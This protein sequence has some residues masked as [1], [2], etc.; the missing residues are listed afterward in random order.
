MK[1]IIS[2]TTRGAFEGVLSDIKA[3]LCDGGEC[4]VLTTDRMTATVERA[5]LDSMKVDGRAC[6]FNLDVTTF[7][8]LGTK[9][10]KCLPSKCLTPEGSV[11]LLADV[12]AKRKDDLDY[13][14]NA[15]HINGFASELYA[16]FTS[17]RNSGISSLEL[18]E[19]SESF[20]SSLKRKMSDL[21]S[22]YEGYLEAL[23][24]RYIDSTTRLEAFTK[25]LKDISYKGENVPKHFYVID[26][27]DFS[28]PQLDVLDALNSCA[29]SLTVGAVSG[30]KNPN[31]RIYPDYAIEK[32]KA[33]VDN[34]PKINYLFEDLDA[35][36]DAASKNLFGYENVAPVE[37]PILIGKEGEG[38]KRRK[39]KLISTL[40]RRDEVLNLVL[41]IVQKV[42]KGARY[43]DIEVL[44]SDLKGYE[45]LLKSTLT[46][47]GV[48][49][50]TDT[51]QL[52]SQQ[53]KV[54]FLLSAI[55]AVRSSLR[56]EEVLDFV[57][58]PLFYNGLD[59]DEIYKEA[60]NGQNTDNQNKAQNNENQNSAKSENKA[61]GEDAV[62]KF[63]NYVL[64][65]G[66]NFG[67]FNS[68]FS[69]GSGELL[70]AA[71]SVRKQLIYALS[72]FLSSKNGADIG[73]FIEASR[74]FLD[75][76][77]GV[78]AH[79][80]G[81]L[82]SLSAY[83]L[84]CAEQVDSKIK[85]VLDEIEDVLDG[86]YDIDGFELILKSM[87]QKLTISLVPTY[88]D[89]VFV[90]DLESRFIGGRD[91]YILGANAGLFPTEKSGG[92][93]LT[94]HD[95]EL[96]E[97]VGLTLSPNAKRKVL[98][99]LFSVT[100]AIK[101]VRGEL[102]V[103]YA[104]SCPSGPLKPSTVVAQ[105]QS[106]ICQDKKPLP[107]ERVVFDDYGAERMRGT[108]PKVKQAFYDKISALFSSDTACRY[109]VLNNAISA[110]A[111]YGDIEYYRAAYS[112]LSEEEKRPIERLY[113]L[114]E[115]LELTP[116]N[117]GVTTM[118][119]S[120]SRLECY[121][122]C[123][124]MYFL[125]YT[126][127]LKER[128]EGQIKTLEHGT[129]LHYILECFY[130]ALK[131]GKATEKNATAIASSAFYDFVNN[132]EK[133]S[134]ILSG[135]GADSRQLLRVKEEGEK[136][137]NDLYALSLRSEFKPA[138]LEAYFGQGGE[139]KPI[140]VTVDGVKVELEGK[141]DRVDRCG[142]YFAVIDYKTYKGAALPLNEVYYG[143]KLQLYVYVEALYENL[144]LKPAG[145][146]Y[147]PI[148]QAFDAENAR[149][150]LRGQ[151]SDD[152]DIRRLLD[153]NSTD[154]N[155][156]TYLPVAQKG[157]K[158]LNTYLSEE[159]F[160]QLAEYAKALSA[161]GARGIL[162]GYVKP[163]PA[164]GACAYCSY[165]T[166]CPYKE[167][168]VRAKRNQNENAFEI[169]EESESYEVNIGETGLDEKINMQCF[170]DGQKTSER[171]KNKGGNN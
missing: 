25:Y 168:N 143:Q 50:F 39:I 46:R 3:V 44:V 135:G 67:V 52:L 79:H 37:N 136:A 51:K 86:K 102:V 59:L 107:V 161:E 142:N 95:E 60:N 127:R 8:R 9:M 123:P 146:F 121:Y 68:P 114:P 147:L 105:L 82:T 71:E 150:K 138:Y 29:L 12:L 47:Y 88:L 74:L 49:Y 115:K 125:N 131:N 63:E 75:E 21:A 66:A 163:V 151:V 42:R 80:T 122:K 70:L 113:N 55:A 5:L 166:I 56:R 53:T 120:V 112:F 14:R 27:T 61:S 24:G 72:P 58:N 30:M 139:L 65:Y 16:A 57:K 153:C 148:F 103:S 33:R 17:L 76:C 22:V 38:G 99:E 145:V 94:P 69:Y 45:P 93:V 40:N 77:E 119:T 54:R 159:K 144:N 126:L 156:P 26:F 89:C 167:Q 155:L 109:E 106:V 129:L 116:L 90:G 48:P 81:K 43:R 4:V 110:R 124:F 1:L 41:D 15:A 85:S 100:E 91:L 2:N 96:L 10:V 11:M 132:D 149:Y 98:T 62:F 141:I 78:W 165:S 111:P 64:E 34:N 164:D 32:L 108:S 84:K 18:R 134:R 118:K 73:E 160:L 171:A 169:E 97:T 23:G 117:R 83:Y 170:V 87:L 140:A 101:K 130:R 19:K 36:S 7:T 137:C 104:E 92:T 13:Y 157:N 152:P 20:P 133:L 154:K 6:S 31:R 162:N 158:L 28:V 128:E 35:V